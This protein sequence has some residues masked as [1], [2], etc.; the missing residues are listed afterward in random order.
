MIYSVEND[1]LSEK[2]VIEAYAGCEV[3]CI[4]Y[5][6]KGQLLAIGG[7][8]KKVTVYDTQDYKVRT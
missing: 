1:S 4:D 2:Q 3:N 8:T 6:S 7:S 5:D